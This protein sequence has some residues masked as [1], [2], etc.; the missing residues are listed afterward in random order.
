MIKVCL[1]WCGVVWLCS[2][3]LLCRCAC[4]LVSVLYVGCVALWYGFVLS[5]LCVF[6]L[7]WCACVLF[8]LCL[9]VCGVVVN[10]VLC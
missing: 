8:S 4:C 9:V 3:M 5:A 6:A 10:V 2:L 7:F 1:V